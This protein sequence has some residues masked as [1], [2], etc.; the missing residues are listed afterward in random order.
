MNDDQPLIA[1]E[2]CED[3]WLDDGDNGAWRPCM[4]CH[5]TYRLTYDEACDHERSRARV[6][7]RAEDGDARACEALELWWARQERPAQYVCGT[8]RRPLITCEPS[9][10][11]QRFA[12]GE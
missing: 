10:P 5:G 3:G 8:C 4:A 11:A 7:E 6:E 12:K 1:C 9:C 2:E